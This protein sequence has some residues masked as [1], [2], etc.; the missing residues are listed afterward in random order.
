[1]SRGCAG[2]LEPR[3]ANRA[4]G[5]VLPASGPGY[6]LRLEP[7]RLDAEALCD[8]LAQAHQPPAGGGRELQAAVRELDAALDLW[9]GIPLSGIPGPWADAERL[10]LDELRLGTV[11]QSVDMMLALGRHREVVAQLTGL[12]REHPLRE[13]FRE[14]L[15]LALYRSGRQAD[16]LREFAAAR[17]LL[18]T[19]LG[20]EPGPG[21]RGL[22]QQ[23]LTGD[24]GLDLAV[25]PAGPAPRVSP[26]PPAFPA[27]HT[28]RTGRGTPAGH[29]TGAGHGVPP[30]VPDELP[31][32]VAAFTGREAE[33]AGLDRLLAAWERQLGQGG[34]PPG[35]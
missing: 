1:M 12:I 17:R 6:L 7:W 9:Q 32:D 34:G 27:P 22:H 2:F 20:I 29:G 16:A 15:M 31:A 23:I 5:Q 25:R 21:L 28:V 35:W 33:M 26:A 30:P 14:Q 24:A 8:H 4:P 10:R 11:E 3:R 13:R 18:D 19:E